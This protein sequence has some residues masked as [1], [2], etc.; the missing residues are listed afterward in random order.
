MSEDFLRLKTTPKPAT[1]SQ[2][3][4]DL[5]YDKTAGVFK[6]RDFD[7]PAKSLVS[8]DGS[9]IS[10]AT[11]FRTA[12]ELDD[13]SGNL[14][15]QAI[16]FS[17][18]GAAALAEGSLGLNSSGDLILHN[19]VDD[20]DELPAASFLRRIAGTTSITA[21]QNQAGYRVK[22]GEFKIPASRVA[23]DATFRVV[24][25]L[26]VVHDAATNIPAYR[27]GF[28]PVESTAATRAVGYLNAVT[29]Q[30]QTFSLFILDLL[31][32]DNLGGQVV[33]I[34]GNADLGALIYGSGGNATI[35]PTQ[36]PSSAGFEETT[37]AGQMMT[38]GLY[39]DAPATV[40]APATAVNFEF[41][42]EDTN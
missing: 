18:T 20:G 7:G 32:L 13:G 36:G 6:T 40:S 31:L 24:G 42:L 27:V 21:A 33:V 41:T 5:F 11:A 28:C 37:T 4:V 9:G 38:L 23:I 15:V 26:S 22:L 39:Y 12:I 19:G 1:P 16:V 10:D 30:A 29:A 8:G 25:K 14:P 34:A 3:A 35:S 17:N 2:G